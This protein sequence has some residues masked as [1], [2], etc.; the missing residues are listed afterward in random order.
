[1][2]DE[3]F[4]ARSMRIPT[5]E[6][7]DETSLT[8]SFERRTDCRYSRNCR[9]AFI[10]RSLNDAGL[11]CGVSA[12]RGWCAKTIMRKSERNEQKKVCR[13]N[14]HENIVECFIVTPFCFG[15]KPDVRLLRTLRGQCL[16]EIVY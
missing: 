13:V 7:A 1:M 10:V 6:C 12:G 8:F 16:D 15:L 5:S 2:V 14:G 3:V 11:C 9:S 4:A